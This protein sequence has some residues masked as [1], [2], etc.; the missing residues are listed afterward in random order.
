[1]AA[2]S[3]RIDFYWAQMAARVAGTIGDFPEK[4]FW[5]LRE[6]YPS[7]SCGT[8]CCRHFSTAPAVELPQQI[9]VT[10]VEILAVG[11]LHSRSE[12]PPPGPPP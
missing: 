5:D 6:K 3:D 2:Q 7:H 11:K 8:S 1:M 9:R 10:P 4:T 12:S